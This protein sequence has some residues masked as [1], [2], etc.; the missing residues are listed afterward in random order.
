MSELLLS[1]TAQM[2]FAVIIGTVW[3]FHGFYSKILGGIPR[4]RAIVGRILGKR[5]A[6]G[7]T[8]VIGLMEVLLG[9][10]VFTGWERIACATVQ[11]LALV[12]MN[13]LE[14]LLAGD[15]LISALGMVVLN[16][17]FLTL[18]WHWALFSPK[19]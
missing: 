4:H 6:G 13:T 3:V 5:F 17:G 2:M 19:T 10:W 18:V 15:L 14:I 8:K 7:A 12:G 1:N 9:L 16:A 11:T